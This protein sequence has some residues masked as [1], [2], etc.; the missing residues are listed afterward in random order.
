[1]KLYIFVFLVNK[2]EIENLILMFNTLMAEQVS[3]GRPANG[4][5]R[6][7]FRGVLQGT[8]EMTNAVMMDGGTDSFGRIIGT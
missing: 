2:T 4:L 3:R 1:M 7:K 5:K 6:G 8:F